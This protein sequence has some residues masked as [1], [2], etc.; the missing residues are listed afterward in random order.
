MKN[1]TCSECRTEENVKPA[2]EYAGLAELLD[3]W[4][5]LDELDNVLLC[6]QCASSVF[7][8]MS[9]DYVKILPLD[10]LDIDDSDIEP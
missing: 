5:L 10:F 3:S 7:D 9:I 2:R 8:E 1:N 4:Y 6:P